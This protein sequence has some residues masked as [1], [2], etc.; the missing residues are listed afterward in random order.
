MLMLLLLL[1]L[2]PAPN[3]HLPRALSRVVCQLNYEHLI[4]FLCRAVQCLQKIF[5]HMHACTYT[6]CKSTFAVAHSSDG[7]SKFVYTHAHMQGQSI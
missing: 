3:M 2:M 7:S 6:I 1:L 5:P 4:L